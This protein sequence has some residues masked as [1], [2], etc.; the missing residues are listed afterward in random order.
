V[1]IWC[2]AEH[3]PRLAGRMERLLDS[4]RVMD[5]AILR[6]CPLRLYPE[7]TE[8]PADLPSP[9]VSERGETYVTVRTKGGR[10][11]VV[12]V[13]VENGS[14]NDYAAGEWGK[15][16][17]LAVD[18]EDFP[19]LART[20]LHSEAELDRTT[21]I[22]GRPLADITRDARPGGASRAGFVAED[23]EVLGVIRRDNRVVAGLGLTHPRLARPLFEV[24]NLIL[25]DLDLYRRGLLPHH[26]ISTLLY[27]RRE[28]RIEAS[29]G[30]GW[31]ESIFSDNV[32][33]YWSIRIRRSPTYM[34]RQYLLRHYGHL[35]PD[36]LS[37]LTEMLT[38]IHTGEMAPF[39]ITRYGFYEGH[40]AYRADPL[41]IAWLFG[42]ASL[43]EID[44]AADGDLYG[45]L[46]RHYETEAPGSSTAGS[47]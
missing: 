11:A 35:D 24:F 4:V 36:E 14:P 30:K 27:D 2:P 37:A 8:S 22:T 46:T 12:P 31:Q 45:A 1:Q 19:T 17:Q 16:R 32:Q 15:G 29:G 39:Y 18:A 28:I 25:R 6:G 13:T 33:G 44:A 7:T 21:S 26:N 41:A 20:G 5:S 47:N 43:E 40:T 3:H 10:Y 42:L 34:E 38:S 23:E 9:F